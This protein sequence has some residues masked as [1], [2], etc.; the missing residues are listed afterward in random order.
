[1]D[2]ALFDDEMSD[3][4]GLLALSD[5]DKHYTFDLQGNISGHVKVSTGGLHAAVPANALVE[6][7]TANGMLTSCN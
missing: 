1:M 7:L 5:T 4:L 2:A 3:V 6:F